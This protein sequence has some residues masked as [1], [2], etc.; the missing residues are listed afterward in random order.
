MKLHQCW[1]LHGLFYHQDF[2]LIIFFMF[3]QEKVTYHQ[4]N[5]TTSVIS[6]IH[7][8]LYKHYHSHTQHHY[9]SEEVTVVTQCI[10]P[11]T[12]AFVS[13]L[14]QSHKCQHFKSKN[15]LKKVL[16]HFQII[17]KKKKK[18]NTLMK[19][20]FVQAGCGML[21]RCKRITENGKRDRLIQAAPMGCGR[22]ALK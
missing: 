3:I 6:L 1:G 20:R 8:Y 11:F 10:C 9:H 17:K 22:R 13:L 19:N 2:I 15:G 7:W 21:R 14:Q 16:L 12:N 5:S 18:K 4:Y